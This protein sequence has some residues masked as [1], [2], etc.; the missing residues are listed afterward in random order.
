MGDGE[1]KTTDMKQIFLLALLF[2]AASTN[3]QQSYPN[4]KDSINP[5]KPNVYLTCLQLG[6]DYDG[7]GAVLR[8]RFCNNSNKNIL[9]YGMTVYTYDAWGKP[10]NGLFNN[11]NKGNVKSQ[12]CLV[13]ALSCANYPCNGEILFS[14]QNE[15]SKVKIVLTKI[16]Y[17]NGKIVQLPVHKKYV[18]WVNAGNREIE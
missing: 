16:K 4:Q 9:N 1:A 8:Y 13:P 18:Y 14:L 10:V 12:D 7:L 3:A 6:Y 15:V 2:V 11:T 5:N 17:S